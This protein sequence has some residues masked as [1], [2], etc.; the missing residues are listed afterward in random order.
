[1]KRIALAFTILT[2]GMLFIVPFLFSTK[3]VKAAGSGYSIKNVNHEIDLLSNGYV[4]INDTI[5]IAGQT[6]NF[7]IGF[8]NK[9]SPYVLRC[10]AFD[11]S[12]SMSPLRLD[13]DLDVP[14]ED[15][16]GFYGV[17]ISFPQATPQFFT[18]GFLLNNTLLTQDTTNASIY[19]LG[20]PAYPSLTKTVDTCNGSI[21]PPEGAEFVTGDVEAFN[22]SR[23][24]LDA[25]TYE[26][27][28]VTFTLTDK[29]LQI[30]EIA[31]F[32]RQIVIDE[33]G[34]ITGSDTYDLINRAN[35]LMNYTEIILP[36]NVSNIRAQDQLGR[37]MDVPNA[38]DT[39]TNRYMVS[40]LSPVEKDNAT[41]FIV[42]YDLPSSI[43]TSKELT[44]TFNFSILL[45]QNFNYYIEEASVNIVLPEGARAQFSNDMLSSGYGLVRSVFQETVSVSRQGVISLDSFKVGIVYEYNPLWAS[46]RPALWM[47]AL[48]TVGCTV[49]IAWK[50]PKGKA[51][52]K[53]AVPSV[54]VRFSAD[55]IRSFIDSY[56]E[57]RKIVFE[58]ESLETRVQKGRIPRRK[59][60]VQKKTL[61]TRLNTLSRSFDEFREKMRVAGGHYAELMLQSEVAESELA[62][63]AANIKNAESLHNRG[64]LS[65]EAYRKR[66]EDYQRRK[67][68]ADTAISGILLRLREEIR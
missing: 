37:R 61:E 55:E 11:S 12:N 51:P 23:V 30:F 46:F 43:Y 39:R 68:K 8:P 6:P 16:I 15:H 49:A 54:A 42:D 31:Q 53:V 41:S 32:T 22:Y 56:E 60:K 62:E 45:F 65:L 36:L 19:T 52:V 2:V 33:L 44:G 13:T 20:F 14:L 35:T 28:N 58:L 25:F 50:R 59:Y 18:V 29:T 5:E 10:D 47:W 7:L 3:S 57:K 66:L 40:F 63:V 67:E 34:G 48:A 64:E 1:M 38:T 9:Y 17:K 24:H 4:F 27:S 21:V 26:P